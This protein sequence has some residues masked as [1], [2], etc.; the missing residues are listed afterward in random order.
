MPFEPRDLPTAIWLRDEA[1]AGPFCV[2]CGYPLSMHREGDLAC[3]ALPHP[4]FPP[5]SCTCHKIER[6]TRE[7]MVDAGVGR[8]HRRR[9]TVTRSEIVAVSA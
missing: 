9:E 5:P 8:K 4:A 3:R 1:I 2:H 6:V 7:V